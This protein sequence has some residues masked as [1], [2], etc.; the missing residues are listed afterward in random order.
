MQ[1]DLQTAAQLATNW[2]VIDRVADMQAGFNW[3]ITN[4]GL[5][6]V[7][8]ADLTPYPVIGSTT[9]PYTVNLTNM[10]PFM[11]SYL[12]ANYVYFQ[13]GPPAAWSFDSTARLQETFNAAAAGTYNVAISARGIAESNIWADMTVYFG[14]NG[15]QSV[16]VNTS[17]DSIY[18]FT[19]T[20]PAGALDLTITYDYPPALDG[21]RDFI[22]DHIQITRQ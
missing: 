22:V 9:N 3:V 5:A 12:N 16:T 8:L 7:N 2:W 20:V 1:A 21:G 14:P 19:F 4:A 10:V 17:S 13:S 15:G 18:N 11:P 6:G